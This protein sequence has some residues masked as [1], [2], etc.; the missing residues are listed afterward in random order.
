MALPL[1]HATLRYRPGCAARS[2]RMRS[3]VKSHTFTRSSRPSDSVR[4]NSGD[5]ATSSPP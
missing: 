1:T 5:S 3:R 4:G 2:A